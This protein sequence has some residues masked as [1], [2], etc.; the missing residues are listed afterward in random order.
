M[1]ENI[2]VLLDEISRL[3]YVSYLAATTQL[4]QAKKINTLTFLF[5][6][7]GSTPAKQTVFSEVQVRVSV[8]NN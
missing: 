2:S 6:R 1:T 7:D 8:C 4:Q 5:L 3:H